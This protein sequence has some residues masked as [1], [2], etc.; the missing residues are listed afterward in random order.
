[1]KTIAKLIF[2]LIIASPLGASAQAPSNPDNE[3]NQA[4]ATGDTCQNSCGG[5]SVDE[6]CWCDDLCTEYED[7]C[8]DYASLCG[9]QNPGEQGTACHESGDTACGFDQYCELDIAQECGLTGTPGTCENRP[10]SCDSS[11]VEVCGC[12]GHTYWNACRAQKA[13]VSISYFGACKGAK[14]CQRFDDGSCGSDEY[15]DFAEGTLGCGWAQEYGECKPRPRDCNFMPSP[16]CGCDAE[17]YP[18]KCSAHASGV[19]VAYDGICGRDGAVEGEACGG[20]RGI[21]CAR[22][23]YCKPDADLGCDVIDVAGTCVDLNICQTEDDPVCGCD[24]QSYPNECAADKAGVTIASR[25]ACHEVPEV[26]PETRCDGPLVMGECG[27]G[28]YCDYEPSDYCGSEWV[29][30]VCKTGPTSC[31]PAYDPVCGCDKKVYTSKCEA[32]KAGVDVL[33]Y[34]HC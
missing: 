33:W 4:Y 34:G 11:G 5:P 10:D 19:S 25:G 17:Q 9:D 7:C 24:G 18:N 2:T 3:A 16:V 28:R 6:S 13:G 22:G 29:K 12:D 26:E 23:L 14:N 30:A 1:M 27:A 20:I 8:N 31:P 21:E 15:C 32:L